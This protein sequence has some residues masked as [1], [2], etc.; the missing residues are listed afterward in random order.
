MKLHV[1]A[2]L[3]LLAACK[4]ETAALPPAVPMTAQSVGYFCQMNVLE[5]GG[6]KGQV[7]LDGLPGK[8]LFFSQ[9]RDTVAYLRMPEQN[10]KILAT[11]VSDMGAAP[12]WDQPG[13]NNWVLIDKAV[14]VVGSDQMGGMDQPEFI[15]FADPSKADAF[16]KAHGGQVMALQDIPASALQPPEA[17]A[18]AASTGDDTDYT[19]RLRAQTQK[20]G[21]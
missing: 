15:P 4:E 7:A 3:L 14:F 1:L 10:Y 21:G 11:Y 20:A 17:E 18:S 9:V 6:P 19:A 16:A 8:P 12:S 5:H 2:L 13:I